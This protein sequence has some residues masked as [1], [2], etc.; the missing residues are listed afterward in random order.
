M[1]FNSLEFLIFFPTVVVLYFT[2]P[3][4]FRWILLLS[5]SYFFYGYWKLEYLLLIM[6]STG[7]NY[8]VAL[9]MGH[10]EFQR[11]RTRLLI[12]GLAFNL[13]LLFLFKY[14][15]FFSNSLHSIADYFNVAYSPSYVNLLLPVGIS[16]YTF[17]TLS[18]VVDVYQGK[19]EPEKH[20]GFFALYVV[21]FSQLVAGPIERSQAL[22]PQFY[23]QHQFDFQRAIDGLALMLWGFFKKIVIADRLAILVDA[24]YAEPRTHTSLTL[25]IAT[26]FFAFQI[27]CDFSGY[28][29]IAIGS[30]KI[31]G[32]DLMENFRR[33]YFSRSI[34]EFW[35]RWHISL[36]NWLRD[37]LYIP[38]GGSRVTQLRLCCNLLIVFLISGLW[39]GAKWTFVLWGG[40]HGLYLIAHVVINNGMRYCLQVPALRQI[41]SAI[42]LPRALLTFIS[43][44]ITFHLV[45]LAWVL[46]RANSLA[47]AG[48]ILQVISAAIR[49]IP[50]WSEN[51]GGAIAIQQ[52]GA[53]EMLISV[54]LILFMEAVHLILEHP[55]LSY[56]VKETPSRLKWVTC[57]SIAMLILFLGQYPENNTFI[58]FQ[59]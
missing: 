52:F 50:S 54:C 37:Y 26:Y 49:S 34:R 32:Y 40:L 58:Y 41:T 22:I 18:Y 35:Q 11:T 44:L 9:Q 28:S 48:Y 53:V 10:S 8:A 1:L 17:Q 27:Y 42:K 7:V 43:I 30:A 23:K 2:F 57:Y 51:L 24:V 14:F 4:R 59:F 39:H 19:Q 25:L 46:F 21:F 16:F 33:P 47:D 20:L 55:K 6:I 36:S 38:L 3:H 45:L 31:L 5:A 12:L 56:L 29:D 15:N 13:G